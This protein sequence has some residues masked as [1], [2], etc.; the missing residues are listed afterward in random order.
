MS[1]SLHGVHTDARDPRDAGASP[2]PGADRSA[3]RDPRYGEPVLPGEG[4]DDYA[5]YMR[6]DA[7]LSLQR[8]P[9]E[10]VHRDELLF[11]TVHQSTE[12]W[13]KHACFELQAVPGAMQERQPELAIRLLRRAV[14]A[15]ELL[16]QQLEMLRH[17]PPWDFQ[18][19]RTAL[20]HGSGFDSPGWREART[21]SPRLDAAFHALLAHEGLTLRAL[22]TGDPQAPLFRLAESLLD[23]DEAIALWRT[24]HYKLALRVNGHGAVTTQGRTVD[25]LARL[26]GS[27]FFPA[28]WDVRSELTAI[29][30]MGHRQAQPEQAP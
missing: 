10:M 6:T 21:L 11:Q 25:V 18:T 16:T 24:R 20:G 13:L 23:W 19:L 5:R 30:P 17:L 7:L 3:P 27:R 9:E 22:Y 2:G 28:L 29:G 4:G 15:V 12:L 14:L 26:V 8:R 1:L